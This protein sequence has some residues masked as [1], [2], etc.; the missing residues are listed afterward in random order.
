MTTLNRCCIIQRI[1][2]PPQLGARKP[3]KGHRQNAPSNGVESLRSAV[4]EHVAYLSE[5]LSNLRL[6]ARQ[7]T[8]QIAL[9][10]TEDAVLELCLGRI[11]LD[12]QRVLRC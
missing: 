5:V 8:H 1:I 3:L 12:C 6:S 9:L 7:M 4:N 11:Q 10:P 2:Q